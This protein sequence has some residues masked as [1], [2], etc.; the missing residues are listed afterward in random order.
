MTRARSDGL[1]LSSPLGT[2]PDD[3]ELTPMPV[4]VP[5]PPPGQSVATPPAGVRFYTTPSDYAD[6]ERKRTESAV[7]R[8]VE[9]RVRPLEKQL[10]ALTD[11][12][13]EHR[14]WA[15]S[16]ETARA[17]QIAAVHHETVLLR[18]AVETVSFKLTT[19]ARKDEAEEAKVVARKKTRAEWARD[20]AKIGVSVVITAALMKYLVPLI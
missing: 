4:L 14:R 17:N 2:V 11:N 10:D 18:N 6:A 12:V 3:D 7:R 16:T 19:L 1:P 8:E 9:A 5:P 20:T 13:E 15:L